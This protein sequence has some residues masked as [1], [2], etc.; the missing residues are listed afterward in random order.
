MQFRISSKEES[1]H[2]HFFYKSAAFRSRLEAATHFSRRWRVGIAIGLLLTSIIL[3]LNLA[4]LAWAV[5]GSHP[6]DQYAIYT[7]LDRACDNTDT[8]LRWSR[9]GIN[10]LSTLLLVESY[11]AIQV[12]FSPTRKE[13]DAAHAQGIWVDVGVISWRNLRYISRWR[14]SLVAVFLVSSAI[15]HYQCVRPV[16]CNRFRTDS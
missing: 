6:H 3:V 13:I 12:L 1:Q 8:Y 14:T 11:Y 16:L 2:R 10:C 4:L 9:L 5:T 7:V 15:V